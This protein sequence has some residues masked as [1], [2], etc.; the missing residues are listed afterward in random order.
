LAD[1]GTIMGS[2]RRY[3]DI[4]LVVLLL[5][6][7]FFFLRSSIRKPEE[8]G[9]VDRVIMQ[10]AA[11]LQY[12]A[13]ALARALTN[14]LSEYTLLVDVKRDNNRLAYENAQLRQQLREAE[15]AL[16]E[17]RRYKRLLGLRDT[18]PAE[19][20][21]A[22]VMSKDYTDFFRVMNLSVDN[23]QAAVRDKMPVITVDGVVGTVLRVGG[24]R[25]DVRLAVDSGFGVDVVVQRTGARGF[26]K[27]TGD[28]A[29]YSVRVEYMQRTDQVE[30]GDLL[31]TSGVGCS[32]PKDIPVAR[33]VSV[34]KKDF[35]IY[36][37]VE[38]EPTVDFSRL[39]ETLIV[40]TDAAECEKQVKRRSAKR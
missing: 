22:S 11:P 9:V 33:V 16:A 39:E 18:I 25:V 35:G 4:F 8:V 37:T 24:D 29:H 21:S 40:M 1:P 14:V 28:P 5:A 2:F 20:V 13:A 10:V 27:G 36:Q 7:P 38:A 15:R 6:V 12:A 26:V 34:S 30:V 31:L 19:T 3:R 23:P 17:G 32:F